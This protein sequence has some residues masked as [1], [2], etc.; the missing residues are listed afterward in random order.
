MHALA[1][2][3]NEFDFSVRVLTLIAI[4]AVVELF[5]PRG[6]AGAVGWVGGCEIHD[7]S[8]AVALLRGRCGEKYSQQVAILPVPSIHTSPCRLRVRADPF[9]QVACQR[10]CCEVESRFALS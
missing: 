5:F 1:Y 4:L 9:L 10:S 7:A 2:M 6:K 3:P 8:A